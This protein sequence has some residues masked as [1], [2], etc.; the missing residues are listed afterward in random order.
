[1]FQGSSLPAWRFYQLKK[2]LDVW[3]NRLVIPLPR[4]LQFTEGATWKILDG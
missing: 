3:V 2:D 4:F 1:M